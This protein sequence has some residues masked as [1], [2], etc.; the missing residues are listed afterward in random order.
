MPMANQKLEST[1]A[2]LIYRKESPKYYDMQY[3]V[4]MNSFKPD[5][6]LFV[7]SSNQRLY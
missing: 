5:I 3:F 6:Q 1:G 7:L 2:D 4:S